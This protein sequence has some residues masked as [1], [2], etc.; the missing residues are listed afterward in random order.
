MELSKRRN[1]WPRGSCSSRP[2]SGAGAFRSWRGHVAQRRNRLTGSL[3]LLCVV[4][5]AMGLAEATLHAGL[6][7][8]ATA[9][10]LAPRLAGRPDAGVVL[11]AVTLAMLGVDPRVLALKTETGREAALPPGA[12]GGPHAGLMARAVGGTREHAAPDAP[13]PPDTVPLGLGLATVEHGGHAG[14]RT[15]EATVARQGLP[16]DPAGARSQAVVSPAARQAGG[17]LELD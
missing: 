10:S 4:R 13:A 2:T 5:L 17:L 14:A 6:A 1:R 3:G 15:V 12:L 7:A 8:L 9:A 11:L 16:A